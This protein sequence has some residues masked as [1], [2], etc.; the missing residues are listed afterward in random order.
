MTKE[1]DREY[2]AA[3]REFK[4]TDAGKKRGTS[5]RPRHVLGRITSGEAGYLLETMAERPN[6][7]WSIHKLRVATHY[8]HATRVLGIVL[9]LKEKGY[10]R[11]IK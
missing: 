9:K 8:V 2:A 10:V 6:S 7:T 3:K 1:I 4:L 11:E 5:V